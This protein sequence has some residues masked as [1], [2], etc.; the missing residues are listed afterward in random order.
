MISKRDFYVLVRSANAVQ[1][2]ERIEF[3]SSLCLWLTF[4][5]FRLD[6]RVFHWNKVGHLRNCALLIMANYIS[7]EFAFF[8]TFQTSN[9]P[10]LSSKMGTVKGWS[11]LFTKCPDI[12]D[13]ILQSL[14][15]ESSLACRCGRYRF[16]S[17]FKSHHVKY[18]VSHYIW[19]FGPGLEIR[20]FLR[21]A[22]QKSIYAQKTT[23]FLKILDSWINKGFTEVQSQVNSEKIN[24][25][26]IFSVLCA[27]TCQFVSLFVF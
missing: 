19:V 18:V 17:L 12:G 3:S 20:P 27:G 23:R 16:F 2:F 26:V 22:C 10:V 5:D 7:I 21:A 14:D 8:L 15:V 4:E 24:S 11:D 25:S 9:L 6:K 13:A 1:I